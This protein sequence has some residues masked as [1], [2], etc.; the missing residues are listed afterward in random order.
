[1]F[2]PQ[3]FFHYFENIGHDELRFLVVFNDSIAEADDDIGIAVS[4]GGIA[5][6]V[7][8]A[9]FGVPESVFDQIPKRHKEVIIAPE[10]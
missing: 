7:L 9:T 2:V 8:A 3:G 4:L 6:R 1:V 5:N 10:K